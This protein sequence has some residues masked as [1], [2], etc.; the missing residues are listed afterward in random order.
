VK[1]G[2]YWCPTIYVNVY[3]AEGRAAAG[4]PVNKALAEIQPIVFAKALKAGVKIAFGTDAGGFAWT[5]NQ[6]KEFPY[7]VRWGMTPMQ[8]IKS[9]TTVAAELLDMKGKLGEITPGAL[10]DLIAVDGDPLADIA[11]L[12]AVT[13][14]MKDGVVY[15]NEMAAR[16]R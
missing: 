10:A 9:A 1:K 14:V 13:F 4:N 7:M 11:L 5:E 12:Q 15:K 3:V 6:A 8:A 2:V 16:G